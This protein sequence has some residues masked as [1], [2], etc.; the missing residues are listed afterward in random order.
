MLEPT[1]PIA[2]TEKPAKVSFDS[3][4][5]LH[6][7]LSGA[8]GVDIVNTFDDKPATLSMGTQE[9]APALQDKLLGL[10]EGTHAVFDMPEGAVFGERKADMQQW[11]S[12]SLLR[13]MGD[14]LEQYHVGEVVQFPAPNGQGTYAGVVRAA[15]KDQFLFDFNHPL[16]GTAVRFEVQLIGVL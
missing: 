3:F 2:A 5:T 11:V 13:R 9:L 1:D 10:A 7:R 6:Y 16:A 14:P 4:L 15:E 8:D 12:R